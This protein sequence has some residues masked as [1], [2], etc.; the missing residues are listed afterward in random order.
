[1]VFYTV[2]SLMILAEICFANTLFPHINETEFF[3]RTPNSKYAGH[4]G[5]A[6]T[7]E[8]FRKHFYFSG[9][10]EFLANYVKIVVLVSKSSPINTKR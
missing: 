4:P 8:L 7:A 10:V 1:M 3:L 6:I 2:N 9:F 5:F